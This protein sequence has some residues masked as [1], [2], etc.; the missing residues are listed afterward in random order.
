MAT[1]GFCHPERVDAYPYRNMMEPWLAL[2]RPRMCSMQLPR[3]AVAKF[4]TR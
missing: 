3:R 2:P 4:W 1:G